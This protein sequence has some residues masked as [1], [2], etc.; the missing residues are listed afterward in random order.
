MS[1][2]AAYGPSDVIS[3][4]APGMG[5]YSG[6]HASDDFISMIQRNMPL[7]GPVFGVRQ[8]IQDVLVPDDFDE[9][10]MLTSIND[11]D[12]TG[13]EA[14]GTDRVRRSHA[15]LPTTYEI[16]DSVTAYSHGNLGVTATISSDESS[17]TASAPTKTHLTP[18]TLTA[19]AR[20][21]LDSGYGTQSNISK[22]DQASRKRAN[23]D[24]DHI[25]PKSDATNNNT[26]PP[27][28]KKTR[29]RRCDPVNP[30][31]ACPFY[32]RN[33]S[34]CEH[35]SCVAPGFLDIHRLKQ[36]LERV[37][38][39]YICER[40]GAA[41]QANATGRQ[42]LAMHQ[43]NTQ[44]CQLVEK[45]SAEISSL[46]HATFEVMRSKRGAAGKSK[47]ERWREIYRLVFPDAENEELRKACE[48]CL[49]YVSL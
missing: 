24:D 3:V 13:L 20:S 47:E 42:D 15:S 1:D 30:G 25:P 39:Y 41:F 9:T 43:R 40:C 36:H 46:S 2:N 32:V 49:L 14:D 10:S 29:R 6:I 27:P 7:L 5:T 4:E 37:H 12:Y 33:P 11:L 21:D 16:N 31:L 19:M 28:R 34:R 48:F 45:P 23:E 8:Q 22:A 38:L 44:P 26:S 17:S 35:N 18:S